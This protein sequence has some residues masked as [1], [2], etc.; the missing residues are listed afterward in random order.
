MV[1]A[2]TSLREWLDTIQ[3]RKEALPQDLKTVKY[4]DLLQDMC[5][6]L[7]VP[8]E[9]AFV[10]GKD[11]LCALYEAYATTVSIFSV[12]AL[13]LSREEQL[14]SISLPPPNEI[15]WFASM[16]DLLKRAREEALQRPTESRR[17]LEDL[18][19]MKGCV[20]HLLDILDSLCGGPNFPLTEEQ[21]EKLNGDTQALSRLV[22]VVAGGLDLVGKTLNKIFHAVVASRSALLD[23]LGSFETGD[24]V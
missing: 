2:Q 19:L 9:K 5:K 15:S 8:G 10:K 20:T 16:F 13:A 6:C 11:F 23:Q 12:L 17:Y 3:L 24:D 14:L 4:S 1:R 18:H 21:A 22:E 7:V